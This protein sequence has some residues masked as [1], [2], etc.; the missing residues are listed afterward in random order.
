MP[1]DAG[2]KTQLINMVAA[3]KG[4]M[5]IDIRLGSG[6][7]HQ[8]NDGRRA[9]VM[10]KRT[11]NLNLPCRESSCDRPALCRG[12]CSRHYSQAR[13]GWKLRLRGDDHEP[14]LVPWINSEAPAPDPPAEPVRPKWFWTGNE[15]ALIDADEENS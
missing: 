6:S 1:L 10:P 12:F 15:S 5:T 7:R 13:H 2:R 4:Q 11:N 9:D 8:E 3:A 14:M